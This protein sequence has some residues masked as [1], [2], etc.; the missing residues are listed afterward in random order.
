MYV[1]GADSRLYCVN[2]T[3]GK[4]IWS[5]SS[6]LPN[7]SPT[8]NWGKVFVT[9]SNVLVAYG[10]ATGAVRWSARQKYCWQSSPATGDNLVFVGL[11]RGVGAFD[12]TT[13]R[14]VWAM[15]VGFRDQPTFGSP[16]YASGV[17]YQGYTAGVVAI[18]GA[19]GNV[20]WDAKLGNTGGAVVANGVVY[21]SSYSAGRVNDL[22][23]A[24]GTVLASQPVP[25]TPTGAARTDPAIANGT[26]IL[27]SDTGDVIAYGL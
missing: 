23:P 2:E 9:G 6:G 22:A 16:A 26:M 20:L 8:V 10:A 7:S 15:S 19:T 18:D 1:T 14:Q 3:T 5:S 17:V 12:A 4:L 25:R 13:G 11:F 21:A 27:G 24:S